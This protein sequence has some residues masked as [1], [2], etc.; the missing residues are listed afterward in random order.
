MQVR[1]LADDDVVPA[2]A[3]FRASLGEP[4]S[5]EPERFA[6]YWDVHASLGAFGDDGRVLGVAARFDSRLTTPGGGVLQCGA[7]PSVG[8][9]PDAHGRGVGRALLSRQVVEGV[10]RGDAVLALNASELWIYG[11]YGYGPT[12]RWW[13]IEVDPRQ[14]AW[15]DD[16]PRAE[17][18]AV[19][20]LDADEL[21]DVLPELYERCFGRWAGELGRTP[22]MWHLNLNPRADATPRTWAVHLGADGRPDAAVAFEIRMAF[23]GIGFANEVTVVDAFGV[24]PHAEALL[25]RWLLER[26]LVGKVT[27][28]RWDPRTVLPWMLDDAR[29]FRTTTDADAMWVRVLDVPE[30]V[31]SRATLVDDEGAVSVR[32]VDPLVPDNEGTWR[33]AAEGGRLTCERRDVA[34]DLTFGVDLL[35]PVLWGYA[36]PSA[37]VDAGRAEAHDAGSVA[38]FDRL[39]AV[40]APSWSSTGI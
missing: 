18:G 32:V 37:L 2:V 28:E 8:V 20:E 14:L 7:V 19:R 10:E 17:P 6:R 9:R 4:T 11:R 13:S 21:A 12:S 36:R 38:R 16:A 34:P 30:V 27:A 22:G 23:D 26:N 31:T 40:T 1:H 35:A 3:A 39:A 33:I 24:D 29:R 25:G 5:R 15:R